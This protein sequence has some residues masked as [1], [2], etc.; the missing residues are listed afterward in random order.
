MTRHLVTALCLITLGGCHLLPPP[1][2]ARRDSGA[3]PVAEQ[4][5]AEGVG[6]SDLPWLLA[7]YH[8]MGDVDPAVVDREYQ[9]N[10][11]ALEEGC[12]KA[13]LKLALTL[14]SQE[15]SG[16]RDL[17]TPCLEAPELR[18]TA[19]QNLAF[20][21][22]TQL[23]ALALAERNTE[24]AH[25]QTQQLTDENQKLRRQVEALKAIE[26]SLQGRDRSR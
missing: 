15:R 4:R 26:R 14:L 9:R 20:L 22:H 6:D 5:R 12:G 19:L 11:A 8:D 25:K 23:Q 3:Q 1:P 16:P 13:R 18:N 17:L 24:A 21:L 10:L 7:Y 2:A